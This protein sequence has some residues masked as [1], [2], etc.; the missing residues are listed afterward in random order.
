MKPIVFFL[1]TIPLMLS[2]IS[3]VSESAPEFPINIQTKKTDNHVQITGTQIFVV[4]P[5]DYVFIKENL[6][7]QKNMDQYVQF[8]VVPYSLKLDQKDSKFRKENFKIKGREITE[9]ENVRLNDFS[10]IYL[11]AP[12]TRANMTE[13]F[14]AFGDADFSV[15]VS[16]FCKENDMSAI[17]E[18]QEIFKSIYYD[19]SAFSESLVN[20][21]FDFDLSVTNFKYATSITN[22][23]I[24]NQTGI[25]DDQDT[26]SASITTVSLPYLE[27]KDALDFISNSLKK[28]L[29]IG[30]VLATSQIEEDIV[31]DR[32]AYTYEITTSINGK[33]EIIR[34]AIILGDSSSVFFS[35]CA[36]DSLDSYG[37][38]YI[39]TIKTI[40]IK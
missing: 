13:L 18:I 10:G 29:N 26:L 21:Y 4:V 40:N 34:E 3:C 1:I 37:K 5:S 30:K 24:Y 6:R 32:F 23:H 9:I 11:I 28:Q 35:G 2:I 25:Y 36:Y 17:K 14:F 16:G 38:K 27:K 12:S 15:M 39:E 7:F 19:K 20:K 8:V 31:N 33:K 22:F